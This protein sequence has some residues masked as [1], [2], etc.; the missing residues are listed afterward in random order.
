MQMA[1]VIEARELGSH[2]HLPNPRGKVVE[3]CSDGRLIAVRLTYPT[4]TPVDMLKDEYGQ[5]RYTSSLC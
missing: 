2:I 4:H 5:M 3:A 1:K